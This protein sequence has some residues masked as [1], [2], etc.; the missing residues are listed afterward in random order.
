[1][2]NLQSCGAAY[3]ASLSSGLTVSVAS[4]SCALGYFTFGHE[5]AHNFGCGHDLKT[6]TNSLYPYGHGHHIQGGYR[7]ILAYNSPGYKT[8]VNY[9]SN[10]SVTFPST[11]TT[12]GI[13]GIAD[14]A[15]VLRLNRFVMADIGDESIKCRDYVT[16]ESETEVSYRCHCPKRMF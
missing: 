5:L 7:T 6:Y 10:P 8:R 2:V 9:Y 16:I 13:S 4:K 12:T 11:S 3:Q 1:M 14:N 15:A